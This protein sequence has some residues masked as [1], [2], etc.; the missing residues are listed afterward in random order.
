MKTFESFNSSFKFKIPIGDWSKDGH[1]QCEIF[2]IEA[3]HP[4]EEI[5]QAYKDSCKL[6][7]ISFNHNQ[8]YTGL[9]LPY[10]HPESEDRQICTEYESGNISKLAEDILRKHGLDVR[11][12]Y[13]YYEKHQDEEVNIDGCEHF[14]EILMKFIKLSLPDMEYKIVKNDVPFLNGFWNKDLNV[15]FGYGLFN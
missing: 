8:D 5:R 15:Q 4:V 10:D 13:D 6:T 11:D 2:D 3:N 12:G 1:N 14:I 9:N 7:G